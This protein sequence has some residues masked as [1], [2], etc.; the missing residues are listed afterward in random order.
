MVPTGH[1]TEKQR[2]ALEDTYGVISI[3]ALALGHLVRL[4]RHTEEVVAF[5]EWSRRFFQTTSD[6]YA[7]IQ[8][9]LAAQDDIGHLYNP[10]ELPRFLAEQACLTQ[11]TVIGAGLDMLRTGRRPLPGFEGPPKLSFVKT[12]GSEI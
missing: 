1:P 8:P 2:R 6:S 10:R 7:R 4:T 12:L 11:L 9:H 5:W 3:R